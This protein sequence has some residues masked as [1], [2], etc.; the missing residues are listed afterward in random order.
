[1]EYNWVVAAYEPR[2]DRGKSVL[3]HADAGIGYVL[4]NRDR[5][6]GEAIIVAFKYPAN[7]DIPHYL[8]LATPGQADALEA[9]YGRKK[10]E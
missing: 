3:S 10:N 7:R 1:M 5:S 8:T 4:Q 2:S 6:K 9:K